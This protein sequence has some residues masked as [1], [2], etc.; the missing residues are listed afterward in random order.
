M[1]SEVTKYKHTNVWEESELE[2]CSKGGFYYFKDDP[3]GGKECT[4]CD[5]TGDYKIPYSLVE[6]GIINNL[7]QFLGSNKCN[8]DYP[9]YNEADKINQRNCNLK[10]ILNDLNQI[11][12]TVN[13]NCV[14]ECPSNYYESSDGT[15][16]YINC[17]N[18]EKYYQIGTRK[19][20]I[21]NC[22][23]ISKFY[24]E[25]S[26]HKEC[27]DKC[28]IESNFYYIPGN[29]NNKCLDKCSDQEK[30]SFSLWGSVNNPQSCLEKC[31]LRFQYYSND[32]NNN[33]YKICLPECPAYF[34]SE[35]KECV[36]SCSSPNEYIINENECASEYTK[37]ATFIAYS[38]TNEKKCFIK[39]DSIQ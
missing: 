13:S 28:N 3:A 4:N 14:S 32:V 21:Q 36:S 38:T 1:K 25:D 7:G 2:F 23:T 17:P 19:K 6:N 34:I 27:L 12:T 15:H 37:N 18:N 9:Y 39:C 31:P 16:C 8:N 20:C 33:D 30:Y 10:L 26:E 5:G 24:V 22:T 11:D 35:T 29:R